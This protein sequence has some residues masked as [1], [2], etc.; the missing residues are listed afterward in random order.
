MSAFWRN[1]HIHGYCSPVSRV[2]SINQ[3]C[4][5]VSHI[6]VWWVAVFGTKQQNQQ[7]M[8]KR[9][10]KQ[11]QVH[12]LIAA[13][14]IT[15]ASLSVCQGAT[16]FSE[17]FSGTTGTAI[18][19]TTADI[20]GKWYDGNG[21]GGDISAE[22]SL[23]TS[24]NGRQLFDSFTATLGAGQML[25]L[26]YDMVSPTPS[27]EVGGPYAGCWAGI[28][29]Y[30]GYDGAAGGTEQMFAGLVSTTSLGKDGAAIGGAQGS[31]DT[32]Q[33][34]HLVLTY[35]Y[36]TGAWTFTSNSGFLSGTGTASLALNG[37]RIANGGTDGLGHYGDINL[38]NVTVNISAVPEPSSMALIGAGMG[39]LM[40]LRRRS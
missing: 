3:P 32:Q 24:G 17:T 13:L 26:S 6:H 33:I 9:I 14:A 29:L 7:I 27:D 40:I 23:D 35:A 8:K 1:T 4:H 31:G 37:L 36:D 39:L 18:A 19:G 20:G 5:A 25:A 15:A 28:S 22:N 16:V 21:N 30:S 38:D 10:I 11:P 2:Y 12:A 34:N